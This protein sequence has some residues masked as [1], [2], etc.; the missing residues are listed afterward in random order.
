MQSPRDR[1]PAKAWWEPIEV[2]PGKRLEASLGAMV[3]KLGHGEGEWWLSTEYRAEISGSNRALIA[4]RRGLPRSTTECFVH[5]AD[6]NDITLS[7]LL[8]DRP[9]VVRPQRTLHL[10]GGQKTSLFVSTPV[11]LRIMVGR[12]P[13]LLAERPLQK[14]SDTWSGPS[15]LEGE[16]CYAT[17]THARQ[18]IQKL[19]ERPD[20]AITELTVHNRAVTPLSLEKISLPVPLLALYCDADNRLLTQALTLAREA[21]GERASIRIDS[22]APDRRKP[23]APARQD[24]SRFGVTRAFHLLFGSQG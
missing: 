5:T 16:M 14:L 12:S 21:D 7:P 17:K 23:L 8:A 20:R 19:P 6:D 24:P 13:T 2:P 15:T 4:V 11:W 3:L 22:G 18:R 10:L 1:K 9:V